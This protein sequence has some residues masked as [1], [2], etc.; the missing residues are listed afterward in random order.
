MIVTL[1]RDV[2]GGVG[3]SF[4]SSATGGTYWVSRR[5]IAFNRYRHSSPSKERGL[6]KRE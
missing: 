6:H 3:E 5:N 1:A 2:D 4:V